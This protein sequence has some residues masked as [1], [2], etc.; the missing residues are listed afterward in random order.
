[1]KRVQIRIILLAAI[2][3][4]GS[5][6]LSAQTPSATDTLHITLDK[7]LEIAL[8]E[9]PIIKIADKEVERTN[10]AK[11]EAI[12][13]LVP[14][15]AGSASYQRV[16]KDGTMFMPGP[17]VE[18]MTGAP[19]GSMPEV[20]A[21]TSPSVN[22]YSAGVTLNAPLFSMGLYKNLQL[23]DINIQVALEAARESKVA[24]KNQVEKAYYAV[25]M[26]K[27]GYE[28]IAVSMKN[29]EDNFNDIKLMHQQGLVAEFDMIS[30]EVKVGNIRPSYIQTKNNLLVADL[31]LKLLMGLPL[32]I[33]LLVDGNLMDHKD[34]YKSDNAL[35]SYNLDQNT[36][37]RKLDLQS[38]VLKKQL[39]LQ[40]TQRLPTLGGFFSYNY[41]AQERSFDIFHYKWYS[42]PTVGLSLNVPIF[43]G[44][45]KR[46]KEKQIRIGIDQLQLQRDYRAESLNVEVR[47]ALNVMQAA[48]EQIKADI[49]SVSLAERAYQI[50]KTRYESGVGTVLEIDNA[51]V[52]Y[53]QAKLNHN[54]AVYSY[55]V[56]KSDY[57]KLLGSSF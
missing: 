27:N 51:E 14:S 33:T 29:A 24:L 40:R 7:A 55:V 3:C 15:I 41:V 49:N 39:Q 22:N 46:N 2:L 25:L 8:S 31:Q 52:A 28:V 10:Y 47:N 18:M 21:I 35:L 16:V 53:T 5:L 9:N 37:L 48:V 12:G 45:T 42:T 34:D 38:D 20:V 50:A 30:A 6:H 26:A 32:D 36:D 56:A 44:F 43:N 19:A 4:I 1:M 57:I 13:N 11:K 17:L 54:Q 23:A